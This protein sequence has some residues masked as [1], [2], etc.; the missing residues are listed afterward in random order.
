MAATNGKGALFKNE[1]K[2]GQNHPDY[3]GNL[4][5]TKEL[6]QLWS[7]EIGNDG[8][9]KV[10]IAAWIKRPSGQAKSN[11]LSLS[12][13]VPFKKAGDSTPQNSRA[14]TDDAPF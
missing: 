5:V 2:S 1:R 9:Y 13:S 8:V 6:L 11:F 3:T 14:A 10:Q 4:E 12:A 7:A